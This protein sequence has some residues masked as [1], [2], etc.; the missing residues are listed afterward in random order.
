M[1]RRGT[2]ESGIVWV[3]LAV[4]WTAPALAQVEPA[5]AQVPGARVEQAAPAGGVEGVQERDLT[6]RFRFIER[7]SAK[8]EAGELNEYLVAYRETLR[9]LRENLQGAP[10]RQDVVRTARFVEKALTVSSVDRRLVSTMLRRY[11]DAKVTPDPWSELG[12]PPIM[13]DVTVLIENAISSAPR[14][15]VLP[16]VRPLWDHE[17]RFTLG[18]PQVSTLATVVPETPLRLGETFAVSRA[19]VAALLGEPAT[20][21]A[22]MGRLSEI[23]DEGNPHAAGTN[24]VAVFDLEGE[25]SAGGGQTSM[26]CQIL[27]AFRELPMAGA[28]SGA[29][30][31]LGGRDQPLLAMGGITKI[32]LSQI[33]Q[34]ASMTNGPAGHELRRELVLERRWPTGSEGLAMPDSAVLAS[35]ENSWL[36]EVDA[37]GRFHFLHPQ[38]FRPDANA[39]GAS[40]NQ[41]RLIRFRGNVPELLTLTFESEKPLRVDSAFEES[42]AKY[43]ESGFDVQPLPPKRL[44]ADQWP[45]AEVY[46]VEAVLTPPAD[47]SLL[48]GGKVVH[49]DGYLMQFGGNVAFEAAAL[50]TS[51]DTVQAYRSVVEGILRTVRPGKP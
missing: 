17:Y 5:G 46:R 27:F 38:E 47:S 14:V 42:F 40:A 41:I 49:F 4:V 48:G 11:E 30:T 51:T 25:V 39:P 34:V 50:T 13:S 9:L 18:T 7:Y 28:G 45:N 15:V 44:P 26:R 2:I 22:I 3:W 43:K 16:P 24:E 6:T 35:P 23:R 37:E 1:A 29:A 32:R 8:P 21:G 19:G 31:P 12:A 36:L 33:S 20:G 10:L